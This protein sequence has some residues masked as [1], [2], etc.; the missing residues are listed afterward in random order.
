MGTQGQAAA[1]RVIPLPLQKSTLPSGVLLAQALVELQVMGGCS[2]AD[3]VRSAVP[4][5]VLDDAVGASNARVVQHRRAPPLAAC[6]RNLIK[7]EL[8]A[9]AAEAADDL[10]AAVAV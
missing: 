3:D 7:R 8:E 1:V 4:G 6:V 9:L 10:V 2:D 5:K